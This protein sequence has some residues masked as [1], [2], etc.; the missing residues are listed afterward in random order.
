MTNIYQLFILHEGS[1][2][3]QNTTNLPG[4]SGL[5]QQQNGAIAQGMIEG[6]GKD[7]AGTL[8]KPSEN[9]AGNKGGQR[10]P[11]FEDNEMSQGEQ[12]GRQQQAYAQ[13]SAKKTDSFGEDLIQTR[14]HVAAVKD[15]FRKGDA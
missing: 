8:P 13:G 11:G 6:W 9:Q 4:S 3:C 5:I 14:L 7:T 2:H 1:H 10:I 12:K 15:L